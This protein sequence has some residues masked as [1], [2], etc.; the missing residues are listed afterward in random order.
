MTTLLEKME[1]ERL[2]GRERLRAEVR[3]QLREVLP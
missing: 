3:R 1:Q 2:Q